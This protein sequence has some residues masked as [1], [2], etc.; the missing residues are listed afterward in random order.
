MQLPEAQ[1]YVG[2]TSWSMIFV[3]GTL[4]R[5][6]F[7]AREPKSRETTAAIGHARAGQRERERERDRQTDRQTERKKDIDHI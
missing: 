2:A 7:S 1:K 5:N 3:D 4:Q 6:A